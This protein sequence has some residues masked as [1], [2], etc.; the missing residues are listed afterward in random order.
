MATKTW[1]I[2]Q[3]GGFLFLDDGGEEV[4]E[5]TSGTGWTVA[6][7]GVNNYADLSNGTAGG[8]GFSTTIVPNTTAPTA[9]ASI[10]AAAPY[11]PPTLIYSTDSISSLYE[12]NGS[13]SAG[14][15]VM[16]FPMISLNS[17]TNDIAGSIVL[18]VFRGLRSG[19]SWTGVT[20]LTSALQTGTSTGLFPNTTTV[21]NSVVT[22]AAPAFK[23]QNE[24]LILKIGWQI[25]DAGGNNSRNI[26]F[27]YGN[28]ATITTPN[29]KRN[30]YY[31]T[32]GF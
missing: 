10:A 26:T 2:N 24:F 31:L 7:S 19:T 22:W 17:G 30:R 12:Y 15:W 8:I 13:F 3:V 14:N 28:T 4:A 32:S 11:T 1:Y 27:R 20:E 16:T 9:D 23:L 29:F 18:R 25:L 6:K 5:V 21:L